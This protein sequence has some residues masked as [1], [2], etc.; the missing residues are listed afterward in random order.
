MNLSRLSRRN[1]LLAGASGAAAAILPAGARAA[2][3]RAP[4]PAATAGNNAPLPA[5]LKLSLAAYSFNKLMDRPGK[6]GE[7]SL[8]D[9]AELA[10]RLEIDA[11]EPTSYY[12]LRSDDEYVYDLKR[13]IF[14][15][16]L[17]ISGSPVGNNFVLPPG[18]ARQ[19]E[20]DR[21]RK[22]VDVCVK[23][24]APAIRIFAG[25]GRADTPRETAYEYVVEAMKTATDYAAS[26]GIF[27]AIE[28]HGY[29]T[30][31]A[32]DVLKLIRAVDHP[33]LGFNLDTG[34]FRDEPYESMAKAAPYAVTC[35]VKT[36][37]TN[38]R[39]NQREPADY[40]RIVRILRDA[41]YRGYI[42][43]EYEADDPH[44][45]VPIHLRKLHEAISA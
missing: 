19:A 28:N 41:R 34:N 1:V 32:D 27:L 26:R 21:V 29:L 39:T 24:G 18:A 8:F 36:L 9:L 37:V 11:V 2:E 22:W 12:F 16:G 35:Q 45:E 13:R 17:D 15:L 33:W 4:A 42:T 43:L 5:R 25:K 3:E 6:P 30:E 44:R 40:G 14:K 31:T 38:P 23:L 20:L 7:M 10:A